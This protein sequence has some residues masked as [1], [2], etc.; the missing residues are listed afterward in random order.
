MSSTALLARYYSAFGVCLCSTG[1]RR[2]MFC[3]SRA[4]SSCRLAKQLY[5]IRSLH[6]SYSSEQTDKNKQDFSQLAPD[7]NC[8]SFKAQRCLHIMLT[9]SVSA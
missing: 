5:S 9:G 2:N 3:T 6:K 7:F 4:A 8:R 1:P